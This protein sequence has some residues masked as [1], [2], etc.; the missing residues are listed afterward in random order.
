[1]LR[2]F[3]DVVPL[4]A[5]TAAGFDAGELELALC[6]VAEIDVRGWR[7]HACYSGVWG[8][9]ASTAREHPVAHDFWECVRALPQAQRARLLQFATGTSRLPVGGFAAL[10]G[11]DSTVRPFELHGCGTRGRCDGAFPRAHTCFNRLDLPMYS[12]RPTMERMLAAL[13]ASDVTGFSDL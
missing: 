3:Y 11:V 8:T 6:G 12:D 4:R 5:L 9:C 7:E 13:L 10:Q 1:M 2:G